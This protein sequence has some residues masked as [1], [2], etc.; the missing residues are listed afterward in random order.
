MPPAADQGNAQTTPADNAVPKGVKLNTDVPYKK[1]PDG[2]FNFAV[3]RGY[4]MY[5]SICYVC[6]GPEARGSSFAPRLMD[7]LKYLSYEDFVSTIMNGRENITPVSNN[8]MPSFGEN[9][10]IVKYIDSL[11]QYLKARADGALEAGVPD[12]E[13]PKESRIRAGRG[14]V[15]PPE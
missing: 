7:S 8:A 4:N 6:H 2:K 15:K 3:Y 9:P 10:T 13:G 11:Y 1:F 5:H 12:W 14:T